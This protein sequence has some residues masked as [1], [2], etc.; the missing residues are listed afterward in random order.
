MSPG[1]LFF[2]DQRVYLRVHLSPTG[3]GQVPYLMIRSLY[4]TPTRLCA[5]I[6]PALFWCCKRTHVPS[7]KE[8]VSELFTTFR[9]GQATSCSHYLWTQI[10]GPF[11]LSLIRLFVFEELVF[12]HY[13]PQTS[14]CYLNLEIRLVPVNLASGAVSHSSHCSFPKSN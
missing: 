3:L 11:I 12:C 9:R 1:V 10:Q 5:Q 14:Q 4:C 8:S 6:H 13:L 2:Y 7:P